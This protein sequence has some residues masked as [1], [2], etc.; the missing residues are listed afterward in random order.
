MIYEWAKKHGIPAAALKDLLSMF[1]AYDLPQR[2]ADGTLEDE[3]QQRVRLEAASKGKILW[4]N[5]VGVTENHVRYGLCNDSPK[6]NKRLKSS[7]CVGIESRLITPEMVG[8]TVGVFLAREIKRPGWVF[9][10][11]SKQNKDREMAQL[12]WML[13]VSAMGGNAA[14]TDGEGSL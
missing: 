4:R 1:G 8:K 3:V 11:G 9:Q 10:K 14:F 5:N 2:A 6:V 13:I 7:D 12:R